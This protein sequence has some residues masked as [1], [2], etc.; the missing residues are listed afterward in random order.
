M[1]CTR[2]WRSSRRGSRAERWSAASSALLLRADPR[3]LD[4]AG[5]AD[6][7]EADDEDGRRLVEVSHPL[8]RGVQERADDHRGE[9]DEPERERD[10]ARDALF[11]L[12]LWLG[13]LVRHVRSSINTLI[14][15]ALF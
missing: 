7:R 9:P 10:D 2:R 15:W 1:A 12:G 3:L 8:D 13:D 14:G 6:E 4:D 5:E 11:F